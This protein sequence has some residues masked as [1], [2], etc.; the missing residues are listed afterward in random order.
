MKNR[1]NPF[2]DDEG[3]HE[4][5][6]KLKDLHL[7]SDATNWID[8]AGTRFSF[9][10]QYRNIPSLKLKQA[11]HFAACSFSGPIA[12]AYAQNTL[13]WFVTIQTCSGRILKHKLEV[14][15]A[16]SIEWTKGHCLLVLDTKGHATIYSALGELISEIYFSKNIREVRASRMFT[17]SRG[18]SG[19]AILDDE[20][21]IFVVNSVSEPIVWSINA[22]S[23]DDP[24]SWAA[25]QPH[26]RL[27]H[28]LLIYGSQFYMG[29]QGEQV[30]IQPQAASW[31]KNSCDYVQS[32]LNEDRSRIVLLTNTS[33]IQIV[34]VDLDHLF[35]TIVVDNYDL[36]HC[37][38]FGWMTSTAVFAQISPE[39]LLFI[40]TSTSNPELQD[41]ERVYEERTG[42]ARINVEPDGIRIFENT[43]ITFASVASRP[44][45]AVLGVASSEDG[46][47]LYEAANY[48][49]GPSSHLAFEY[50][51]QVQD[52]N[53]AIDDCII[54]A[55][56]SWEP[57]MQKKLLTAARFGMAFTTTPFNTEKMRK[58]IKDLRVLNELHAS[59]TGLPITHKQMQIIGESCLINRLV[60]M[61]SYS[62][63]IKVAGWLC[64]ETSENVDRVLLEWVRRAIQ[65]AANSEQR[66]DKEAIEALEMKISNKLMQFP[67]VSIADAAKRAIEAKLPQLARLFIKRETDDSNH[68]SVLLELGDVGAALERA[69][70]AQRP[71]LVHQVIRYLMANR[72]RADYELAISK[73]PLAQCLYQD[74]IRQEGE[75]RTTARKM[76]ALLEQESDFERQ[77]LYH[78]DVAETERN[79]SE[80][81][82]A[83]RRA[84]DA[85]KSMGD[86]GIEEILNDVASFA[87]SQIERGQADLSVR[88]TVIELAHD[89]AKVAQL[90][91]QA[92]LTDKQVYL[93][94]IEGLAKKGK[95]EQLFDL[96]QKKSPVGY[97]PFVKACVRYKRSEED[98]RKYM[99]KVNGYQDLVA[100]NLALKR[101]TEA[102]KLAYD[103]RDIDMLH[104]IYLKS[105]EDRAQYEKCAT[106]YRTAA[107]N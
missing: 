55:C 70:A 71:Q 79:P 85:A 9:T 54:T 8:F 91:H 42:F 68:V 101:F 38:S 17:T 49:N 37:F 6:L 28:V 82:F 100:A 12:L 69:A 86:R 11:V 90:K 5:E 63:A 95:M 80:R 84:R 77:T 65:K 107:H 1:V 83:V 60:D 103:R 50:A 106:I 53:S 40:S 16:F 102:A 48:L 56:E 3:E 34:S 57:Q 44:Q 20:N 19:I 92:R 81:L 59:R 89:T 46:A 51:S 61:G 13:T 7:C 43:K 29:S 35:N 41:S 10:N 64:G 39:Q 88:D 15:D 75:N 96:A 73:I 32:V 97:A 31:A 76:L 22:P 58:A 45:R 24:S 25:F 21:R 47:L 4:N 18:D 33:I 23:K 14:P 2:E 99:A 67:H 27:T 105:H 72:K 30:T 78:F 74:L 98:I 62:V 94:T 26:S 87:P 36:S 104:S 93:W 52:A 66:F